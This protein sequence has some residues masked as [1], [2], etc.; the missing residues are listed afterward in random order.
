MNFNNQPQAF[1]NNQ[2]MN[3]FN[4]NFSNNSMHNLNNNNFPNNNINLNMLNMNSMMSN[5]NMMLNKMNMNS[6]MT[7]NNMNNNMM[8]NN[9]MM[10]P[11]MNINNMPNN[12]PNNMNNN[13]MMNNNNNNSLAMLNSKT[14]FSKIPKLNS[15]MPGMRNNQNNAEK[16]NNMNIINKCGLC[17]KE[18]NKPIMCKYCNE[19]FCS[20]CLH[21]WLKGHDRCYKCKSKI[22][23]KDMISLPFD[24]KSKKN[25]NSNNS[26]SQQQNNLMNIANA[27]KPLNRGSNKFDSM[28]NNN[29]NN[30]NNI[31][32]NN[33][34]NMNCINMNNN[35]MNSTNMNNNNNNINMNNMNNNDNNINMNNNISGNNNICLMHNSAMVY[36][37][38]QCNKEFCSNCLL[39]FGQ[40]AQK[41]KQHLIL[42]MSQLNNEN[43][44]QLL[45]E[46][47]KLP[48]TKNSLDHLIGLSNL[49]IRENEI[50][51]F[52][53]EH[54]M[55]TIQE[56]YLKKI[57]EDSSKLK[58]ILED[59]KR[60]KDII[61]N[62][63]SSIPNGFNNIVNSNDYVQGGVLSQELKKIN[64]F[65]PGLRY[66][67]QEKSKKNPLLFIDNYES[68]FL[69]LKIPFGGKFSEGVEIV[70][71][72]INFIPDFPCR[73]IMK[74]LQ[75]KVYISLCI[76]IK[77]PLN[78]I[79]KPKFFTYISFKNKKYGLEFSNLSEQNFPQNINQGNRQQTNCIDMDADQF[80]YLVEDD[81]IIKLKIYAT[82][83]HYKDATQ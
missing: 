23:F 82:M 42:Q 38:V 7:N 19:V 60:Q 51:K 50:K 79:E 65:D 12:I 70:N 44:K 28:N 34:N 41:H 37:C 40:E 30:N 10:N 8:N 29:S 76:D 21:D 53:I 43:I 73:I 18:G 59:L 54:Y 36:Y 25:S 58:S 46:Y 6:M 31:N 72:N 81:N 1:P 27:S 68:E 49:K 52:E 55:N 47:N 48:S 11:K 9:I 78:Q 24:S 64:K 20:D 56:A 17:L 80:L 67:I 66:E 32:M 14:Y 83:I 39:F 63:I 33:N 13:M 74:Y 35:N 75:N 16:R 2:M 22:K 5:N 3:N 71:Q 45:D 69:E 26:N 4:N 15:L 62:S 61:E 57:D 77:A